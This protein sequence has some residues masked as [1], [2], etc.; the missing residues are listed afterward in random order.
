MRNRT[1]NLSRIH[2]KV[3]QIELSAKS[4]RCHLVIHSNGESRLYTNP[5]AKVKPHR[6]VC[7]HVTPRSAKGMFLL[8]KRIGKGRLCHR[9]YIIQ[10]C[11]SILKSNI[12]MYPLFFQCDR[13]N[14]IYCACLASLN[15]VV[16]I[17]RHLI[18]C[19]DLVTRR[20]CMRPKKWVQQLHLCMS[21]YYVTLL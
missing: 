6:D 3:R 15:L 5:T 12:F 17:G 18:R 19:T 1:G 4:S 11:N 7:R 8:E 10:R 20:A 9:V 14:M 13:Q 16:I 2:E 21:N